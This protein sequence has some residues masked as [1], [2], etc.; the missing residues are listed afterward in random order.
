[1]NLNDYLERDGSSV[2]QS[3]WYHLAKDS[4]EGTLKTLTYEIG[5]FV[6]HLYN[7][8]FLACLGQYENIIV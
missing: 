7:I 6:I 3:P 4:H 1:M 8:P 2:K 5:R